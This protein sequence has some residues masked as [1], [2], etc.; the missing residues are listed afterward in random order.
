[1]GVSEG[2][3]WRGVGVGR[4]RERDA[5]QIEDGRDCRDGGEQKRRGEGERWGGVR[6]VQDDGGE[7]GEKCERIGGIW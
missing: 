4:A 5:E 3:R 6:G 1:M 2:D 7:V